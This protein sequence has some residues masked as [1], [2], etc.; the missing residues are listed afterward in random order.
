MLTVQSAPTRASAGV[1]TIATVVVVG[2]A[3][4]MPVVT[5]AFWVVGENPRGKGP[6]SIYIT[7]TV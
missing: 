2:I 4:L 1:S 7:L 5:Y 3:P 6:E